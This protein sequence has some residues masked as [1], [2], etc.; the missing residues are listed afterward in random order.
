[1]PD[2]TDDQYKRA[3][4]AVDDAMRLDVLGPKAVE[5]FEK[6]APAQA[7]MKEVFNNAI[8]TEEPTQTA[9]KAIVDTRLDER[10]IKGMSRLGWIGITVASTIIG[11]VITGL[12]V[13]NL[14]EG[15]NQA[16][17]NPTGTA[18]QRQ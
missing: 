16:Q 18:Q 11:G 4:K 7:S 6:Y 17:N 14:G 3:T 12:V 5:V 13:Y 8:K 1:M 2:E 10:K 9:I 15:R